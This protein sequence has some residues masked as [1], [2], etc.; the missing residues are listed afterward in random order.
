M[1]DRILQL[2]LNDIKNGYTADP[3]CKKYCC[4][5]CG[6]EFET[7]EVFRFNDRF[8]DASKAVRLHMEREHG[9]MLGILASYNKRYTG[10]TE[11]QKDLLTLM[12]D[13]LS[14]NEISKKTGLAL[15][16]IRHQR[17][18]FRE[19]AKQAKLYLAIYE[20]VEGPASGK[21]EKPDS[22]SPKGKSADSGLIDI[23]AG[24]NM[25][26]DRYIITLAEEEKITAA[27]FKSLQPL[28]LK[29]FP[30]KEKKKLVILRKIASQFKKGVKYTEKEINAVLK[31]IYDDYVTIRRYL[32]EYGFMDRTIDCKEYWIK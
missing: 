3:D 21:R 20:T 8:F 15:S 2:N 24:A 31:P 30:A 28:K 27:V 18:V 23:H 7:G 5:I 22:S 29:M 26:D 17:F 1:I 11:K 10:I 6:M 32:I 13:G 25:V 19:K 9:N 14:D 4:L 12:H 16:T